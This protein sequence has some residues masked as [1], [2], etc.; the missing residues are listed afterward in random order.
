MIQ[1]TLE[2]GIASI[3][4]LRKL[5]PRQFFRKLDVEGVTV[6]SFD[7]N[8]LESLLLPAT[9]QETLSPL[10]A[11]QKTQNTQHPTSKEGQLAT[12][13]LM[14]IRW[15]GK[16]GLNVVLSQRK[17]ARVVFGIRLPKND[18]LLEQYVVCLCFL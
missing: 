6:T 1:T 12:E 13:A 9:T 2:C 11:T 18:E 4:R 3:C 5:F 10:T 17:V 14:L 15:M 16:G 7:V 8:A